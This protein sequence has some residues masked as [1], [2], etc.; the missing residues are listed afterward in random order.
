VKWFLLFIGG[1]LG[2]TLRFA[3]ATW[4]DLRAPVAFPWGTLAVNAAGCF[5]IGVLATYADEHHVL[6]AGARLFLVAGVLGGFTTFSTF[7]LETWTLV[8]DRELP[9]ALANAVGS[10]VVGL[11]A[12]VAGVL[13]ARQLG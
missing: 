3:L 9:L 4:V 6:S 5:A 7:G 1:G 8:E 11:V 10:V 13:I 2:A 12:V